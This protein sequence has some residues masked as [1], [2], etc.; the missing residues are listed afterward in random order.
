MQGGHHQRCAGT[1]EEEGRKD[2]RRQSV[3]AMFF[4]AVSDK[5]DAGTGGHPET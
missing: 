3:R 4:S 1:L 2:R 5:K